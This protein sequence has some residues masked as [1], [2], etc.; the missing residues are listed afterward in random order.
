MNASDKAAF[1]QLLT[2]AMAFYRQDVSTFA[3]SVWWQA[4]ERYE[5]EQVAKAITSHAMDPERGQF[6]P[7]PADIVRQLQGT[8]TDRS[9]IAWGKVLDAMQRVGAYTSVVFDDGAIHAAIEDMGGWMKLCRSQT[10]ELPFLQ[11]RFCDAHKVYSNRPDLAYPAK[12][13]GEHELNNRMAGQ[14]TAPPVL[15]GNPDKAKQTLALGSNTGKTTIT[16]LEAVPAFKRIG[17][18][19][20]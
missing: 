16:A 20:A 14:K 10:D 1:A 4:C 11:R 5:F 9:L 3:V 13:L 12:L 17:T 7:K 2:D 6:A 18:D 15:I 19:A 8:A